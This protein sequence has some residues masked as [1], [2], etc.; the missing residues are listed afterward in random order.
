MRLKNKNR[1]AKTEKKNLKWLKMDAK[2]GVWWD[3]HE[4]K[5]NG[6]SRNIGTR[7]VVFSIATVE[8]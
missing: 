2:A 8:V 4:L 5:V 6:H 7:C 3:I 1:Q